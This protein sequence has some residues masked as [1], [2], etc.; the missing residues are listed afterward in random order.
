[1]MY[2]LLG[3]LTAVTPV[4]AQNPD[5]VKTMPAKPVRERRIC[6]REASTGSLFEKS[7]CHTNAEWRDL[8]AQHQ[9]DA[10]TLRRSSNSKGPL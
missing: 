2:A 3:L 10:E 1:M 5:P 6:R 8:E 4:S 7:V 9:N